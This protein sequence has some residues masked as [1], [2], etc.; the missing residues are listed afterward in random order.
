MPHYILAESAN[1]DIDE[2]LPAIVEDN[3]GAAWNWYVR[4]HEKFGI[5]AHSPHI[6]RVRED[7]L[8]GAFMFP[9]GSYLIFYELI[10]GGIQVVHV[11]H[12]AR[13]VASLY[14]QPSG[15]S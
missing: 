2:I 10:H 13:D 7:L 14:T 6:G 8:P 9:F 1:H 12:G 5:L 11:A 15:N 4:L 3:E